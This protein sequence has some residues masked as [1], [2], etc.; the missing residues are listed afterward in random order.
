MLA[1][2]AG[3]SLIPSATLVLPLSGEREGERER[4]LERKG[5]SV[6]GCLLPT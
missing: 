1:M 6:K 3:I 5:E 2:H 4:E